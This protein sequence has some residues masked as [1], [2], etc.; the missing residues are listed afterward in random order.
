MTNKA[1]GGD[2]MDV[3]KISTVSKPNK[4]KHMLCTIEME[5]R[6]MDEGHCNGSPPPHCRTLVQTITA[7]QVLLSKHLNPFCQKVK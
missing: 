6:S 1:H 2:N 7:A 4:T 5:Q 3:L